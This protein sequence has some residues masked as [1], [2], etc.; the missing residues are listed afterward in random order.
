MFQK[1]IEAILIPNLHYILSQ[2]N[3]YYLNG[4]ILTNFY[5]FIN[6]VP[7]NINTF[8]I[9]RLCLNQKVNKNQTF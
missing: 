5:D 8:F 3:N 7:K 9:L 6:H 2:Q 1:N 4:F